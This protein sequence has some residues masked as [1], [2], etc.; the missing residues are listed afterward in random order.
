MMSAMHSPSLTYGLSPSND[1]EHVAEVLQHR[2]AVA[3]IELVG[4]RARDRVEQLPAEPVARR[5][6]SPVAPADGDQP[7]VEGRP[8]APAWPPPDSP[9]T[10]AHPRRRT[11]MVSM[12]C[13]AARSM[14]APD[15]H[16]RDWPTAL[17]AAAAPMRDALD[18]LAQDTRHDPRCRCG[19]LAHD[20]QGREAAMEDVQVGGEVARRADDRLDAKRTRWERRGRAARPVA[21]R[22][23]RSRHRAPG[24]RGGP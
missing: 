23:S 17:D 10:R 5:R 16:H 22:S 19:R 18:G 15:A 24:G 8:R 9:T 21:P 2:H 7:R 12:P 20:G 3:V 4:D 13:A 11:T 14:T 1:S 6:P